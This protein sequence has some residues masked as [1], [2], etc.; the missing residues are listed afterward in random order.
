MANTS[1]WKTMSVSGLSI[2]EHS[3][4]KSMWNDCGLSQ[5]WPSQVA[6][7][8]P[9]NWLSRTFSVYPQTAHGYLFSSLI[10]EGF[11]FV[12]HLLLSGPGSL[13]SPHAQQNVLVKWESSGTDFPHPHPTPS[14]A[15]GVTAGRSLHLP[16]CRLSYKAQVPL[17]TWQRSQSSAPPRAGRLRHDNARDLVYISWVQWELVIVIGIIDIICIS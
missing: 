16:Q 15:N 6:L 2:R 4:L 8:G 10:T 14:F 12:T 3:I 17:L 7:P 9:Q 5:I 13:L 1:P 11:S